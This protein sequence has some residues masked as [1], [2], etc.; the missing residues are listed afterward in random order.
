MA[1]TPKLM[2]ADELI[3]LPRVR[4]RHELIRGELRTY[5]LATAPE[6]LVTSNLNGSLGPHVCNSRLGKVVIGA[7][8]LLA[9]G[10]D[11]VRAP[12]VGFLSRARLT[13]VEDP[14]CYFPGP[15]DLAVEVVAPSDLYLDVE[16][17]VAEWLEHG[18]QFVFVVNPFR[19][20]VRVHR[21][22][23]QVHVLGMDDTLSSEDVV[24][25]WTLA[26]RDLFDQ[27]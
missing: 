23:L 13:R 22:N 19:R 26:V 16:D 7:G 10:P 20:S 25:G 14:T 3:R 18:T 24:P 17:K 6:G 9:V 27:D 8:F 11:T 15:P 21:P 12:D 4:A 5:P 1:I 2:T